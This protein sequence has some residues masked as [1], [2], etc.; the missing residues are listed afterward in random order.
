MPFAAIRALT[1]DLDDTLWP[2]APVIARAEQA[3]RDWLERHAPATAAAFDA[4]ALRRLRAEVDQAH[5]EWRHD[6]TALRRATL[7]RAVAAAGEPLGLADEAFE[8]F[9]AARQQVVF[10]PEVA[11][12]LQRLAARYPLWS[13]SN[14]N[15]DLARVGI[16]EHFRGSMN[17]AGLGAAKPDRRVFEQACR[18]IGLSPAEVLHVGDDRV[19][20]VDGAR[21]AGLVAVWLRRG[22][23][24]EGQACAEY[25]DEP[26]TVSDLR[27]LADRLGC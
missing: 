7:R 21:A 6:L 3:Q 1:L 23:A 18:R 5:P 8:V 15:A 25:P 27:D 14:G 24:A 16:G 19:M 13:L 17:A 22:P 4:A 12:A 9:F 11:E 20:D 26:L 10:Y 2:V